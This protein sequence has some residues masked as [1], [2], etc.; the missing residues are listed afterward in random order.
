MLFTDQQGTAAVFSKLS[1]P[2]PKLQTNPSSF[3]LERKAESSKSE[4]E[5]ISVAAPVENE[6]QAVNK[7][8]KTFKRRNVAIYG[9]N[10]DDDEN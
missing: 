4:E 3:D 5:S 8:M 2:P 10:D 7:E 6:T 1:L 9:S